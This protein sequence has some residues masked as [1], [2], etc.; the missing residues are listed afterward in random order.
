MAEKV[1]IHFDDIIYNLQSHGGISRYWY[2]ITSRIVDSRTFSIY[3]TSGIKAFRYF[4]VETE[5]KIFHSSYY[6]LPLRKKSKRIVTVHDFLYQHRFLKTPGS[7]LNLKQM[8][9][10]IN[11]ADA[12]VC[13]SESTKRDLL[14][15]YPNLIG[16]SR[17]YVIPHGSSII[18]DK[19]NCNNRFLN[20]E[21]FKNLIEK[22]YI[23]FVGKRLAYK[24]FESALFG[25]LDSSLVKHGFSMICVGSKFNS[26]ETRLIED[27]GLQ[28]SVVALTRLQNNELAYLYKR[29]FALV[30]PSF[31]EGFGI[32]ILEAMKLGCP[33]IASNCSSIPEVVGDAGILVDP[34]NIDSISNSLDMFLN[35]I[36][37]SEY[38]KKGLERAESFSWD[39]SAR[40]YMEIYEDLSCV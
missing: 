31:Y 23:L 29:A 9:I 37:R 10:A 30:Y 4:P 25:F 6:R 33:V 38:V 1:S 3:R 19:S 36:I 21:D 39:R 12:I 24:N 32:P 34:K 2:E 11:S 16:F 28:N 27:L 22:P 40:Q 5:C 13:V 20:L 14:L 26:C 15:F 7:F 8:D 35:E 18:L 17:L